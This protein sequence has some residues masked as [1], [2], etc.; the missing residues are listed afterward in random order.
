MIYSFSFQIPLHYNSILSNCF[1]LN[2]C[3]SLLNRIINLTS[4]KI[5]P[6]P[7][8]SHVITFLDTSYNSPCLFTDSPYIN[9]PILP[10]PEEFLSYE[11]WT[12]SR[13]SYLFQSIWFSVIHIFCMSWRFWHEKKVVA[14]ATFAEKIVE[15]S[16]EKRQPNWVQSHLHFLWTVVLVTISEPQ[17][18]FV[19]GELAGLLQKAKRTVMDQDLGMKGKL[20]HS[21]VPLE[22]NSRVCSMCFNFAK[23]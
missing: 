17:L 11:P 6:V 16:L 20:G 13:N 12:C 1:S 8:I 10:P 22:R 2:S 5:T 19:H 4:G 7:A 21:S 14:S 3:F 23:P 9:N 15:R 18:D